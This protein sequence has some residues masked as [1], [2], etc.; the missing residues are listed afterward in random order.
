M[1]KKSMNNDELHPYFDQ[2][3]QSELDDILKYEKLSSARARVRERVENSN[4][5]SIAPVSDNLP[6]IAVAGFIRDKM[7]Y[8]KRKVAE[9][10]NF[11]PEFIEVVFKEWERFMILKSNNDDISPPDDVDRLWHQIILDTKLYTYYCEQ[12]FGKIIHHDPS[13]SEDQ[14]ARIERLNFTLCLYRSFFKENPH[15]KII[16]EYDDGNDIPDELVD[17]LFVPRVGKMKIFIESIYG[18]ILLSLYATSDCLVITLKLGIRRKKKI[19]V[20]QQKLSYN[21]DYNVLR[22]CNESKLSDYN[23]RDGSIMT[24]MIQMGGC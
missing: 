7:E 20:K 4:I 10:N 12:H 24:L 22:L 18:E 11:E 19:W 21:D 2:N 23:I 8:A 9:A 15:P 6:E 13:N 1:E 14:E 5:S 16:Y 3:D 17:Q